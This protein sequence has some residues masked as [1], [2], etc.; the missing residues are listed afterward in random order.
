MRMTEIKKGQ[1]YAERGGRER[2]VHDTGV[3]L[4]PYSCHMPYM[5]VEYSYT[6]DPQARKYRA[7]LSEFATNSTHMVP[8]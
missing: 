1:V 2:M 5:G 8:R 4:R 3:H 6:D 7:L